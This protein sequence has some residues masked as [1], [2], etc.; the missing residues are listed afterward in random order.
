MS[1]I[2]AAGTI[3]PNFTLRVTPDQNL[4]LSDLRG[5]PV[6]PAFYPADWSP[7]CGDQMTLYKLYNEIPPE[8]RKHDAELLGISVEGCGAMPPSPVTVTCI[9]RC[10]PISKP[11]G[12]VARKIPR[13]SRKRGR[14]R[15]RTICPRST[16]ASSRGAIALRS[17]SIPA[18][19]EFLTPSKNS[20]I[21]Q[22]PIATLRTPITQN[23]H[24]RGPALA[25]ITLVEYGD[26]ECSI[27]R[28]RIPWSTR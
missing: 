11:K 17:L 8:F 4:M 28:W 20:Q 7:V 18:P 9:S 12:D 25:P 5:K 1:P 3:A 15:A 22:N 16:G 6:I 14:L 21:R 23:D 27:V 26:Y 2:L 24:V 13:L 19:T 10:S